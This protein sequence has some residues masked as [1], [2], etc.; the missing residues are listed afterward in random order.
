MNK[1][2]LHREW[3]LWNQLVLGQKN[4]VENP[5][6]I[7]GIEK[8]ING[9]IEINEKV[10]TK[11]KNYDDI[12][13]NSA[14][15]ETRKSL[16]T[17]K[18][19][20]S[21]IFTIFAFTYIFTNFI[22]IN[23]SSIF[24]HT[25]CSMGMNQNDAFTLHNLNEEFANVLDGSIGEPHEVIEIPLIPY[26]NI[27][28]PVYSQILV[29]NTFGASW[30]KP[31]SINYIPPPSNITYNRIILTLDTT[32]QGVQ[33][34]RLLHIYLDDNEIWRSSTIE[35]S[36]K[37]SHSF[38]QKDVTMY[39]SLFNK[40][41][42]LLVQLNNLV[43]PKL[44]GKFEITISALY[45]N[46]VDIIAEKH[47]P[48]IIPL[49]PSEVNNKFPPIVRYPD[50]PLNDITLPT[51]NY[52]ATK[53]VL[54]LTT[55]G[56]A[57]E[58]FWFS[59]VLDE[60]KNLFVSHNRH[61]EGHGSCRVINVFV[62]GVR[63]HSTNPKQVIF[64][65]GVAP[66]LWNSIVSTGAFDLMP[67]H[68]DLTAI[69]PLLWDSTAKL[70]IEITNCIDDDVKSVVKSGVG[71]NWITSASLAVWED[72]TIDDSFGEVSLLDNS[73]TIKSFAIAPPFSGMLT[74]IIKASYS[75]YLQSN[76]TFLYK[77]GTQSN[78]LSTF[79]NTANQTSMIILT[80]FG[81]NQSVLSIPKLNTSISVID[82]ENS[83]IVKQFS[84]SSNSSLANI[85][86]FAPAV[87]GSPDVSYDLNLT[88][89][90]DAGGYSGLTPLFQI[91][92]KE[93]G[94]AEFT[95]SP[96]GN[97]GSGAVL[98]N[99]TLTNLDGEIYSRLALADNGTIVYDNV[100]TT[101]TTDI[102]KLFPEKS[103]LFVSELAELHWLTADEFIEIE[104]LLREDEFAEF[105]SFF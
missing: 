27:S 85:L 62:N 67:Y 29:N 95:I 48:E 55:S 94:T 73:T 46:E 103:E 44:T 105:L 68:I 3:S 72:E 92:S 97:H 70:E 61:F 57:E 12:E 21:I 99:Y 10:L 6:A 30:N 20:S 76:V 15:L 34:D 74:Q 96:S 56:N 98:H 41:S 7:S 24:N 17:L 33:Y 54:L 39:S 49:T 64:T 19:L 59:N 11:E 83:E 60:Y 2:A 53:L 13:K 75:N 52:N 50:A 65:G 82:N 79:E 90:F 43:T 78:L 26:S 100:T 51:V 104:N 42:H 88:V 69:L 40:N 86:K 8:P 80:K 37:L 22:Q 1:G 5:S 89:K 25:P 66:P 63:V 38:A 16:S 28:D 87:V 77:D 91:K 47:Y 31:I 36:G 84:M 4:N 101:E 14:V 93:N 58:E 45:F 32:V 18:F 71:S 81:D 9:N 102:T 35:P 23:D